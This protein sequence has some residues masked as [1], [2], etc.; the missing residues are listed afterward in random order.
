MVGNIQVWSLVPEMNGD[1]LDTP[2]HLP[3]APGK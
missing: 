2:S 3:S 1:R